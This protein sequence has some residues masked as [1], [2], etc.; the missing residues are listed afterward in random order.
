MRGVEYSYKESENSTAVDLTAEERRDKVREATNIFGTKSSIKKVRSRR[1]ILASHLIS[2][3]S[4]FKGTM[5]VP[6]LF[7]FVSLFC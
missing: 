7:P 5:R 6:C 3:K 2:F 4:T 1:F